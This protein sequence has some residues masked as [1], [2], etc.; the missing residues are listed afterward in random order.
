MK[1]YLSGIWCLFLLLIYYK[2]WKGFLHGIKQYTFFLSDFHMMAIDDFV[3]K[4]T[5]KE[6]EWLRLESPISRVR[7]PS[8]LGFMYYSRYMDLQVCEP[9]IFKSSITVM[10][11][12]STFKENPNFSCNF[13]TLDTIKTRW[14]S[15]LQ[16]WHDRTKLKQIPIK[17]LFMFSSIGID[18]PSRFISSPPIKQGKWPELPMMPR[19]GPG[20]W[21]KWMCQWVN[22]AWPSTWLTINGRRITLVWIMLLCPKAYA[23]ATV[24]FYVSILK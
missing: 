2:K 6:G 8:C 3:G 21:R 16:G 20:T 1:L 5:R 9:Y 12:I 23:N 17:W 11:S 18:L 24:G 10:V 19:R 13:F 15:S 4:P 14:N 7:E 22:G